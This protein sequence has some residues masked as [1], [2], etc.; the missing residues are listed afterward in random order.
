M[1]LFFLLSIVYCLL[2]VSAVTAQHADVLSISFPS[3]GMRVGENTILSVE[4]PSITLDTALIVWKLDN[5]EVARGIGAVSTD[6]KLTD[7]KEHEL[8]VTVAEKGGVTRTEKV[9][10][11]ASDLDLLWEAETLTPPMYAGRTL[12]SVESTVR[13]EVI[14]NDAKNYAPGTHTYT[15]KLNGRTLAA[16]S[17]I[18]K[19]SVRFQLPTFE[20]SALLQVSVRGIAGDFTG[21]TSVRIQTVE[22]KIVFYERKA[23]LGL[24]TN[25]TI[26]SSAP[27]TSGITVSAFPYFIS[28]LSQRDKNLEYSWRLG[29][30]ASA[31][32]VNEG[33]EDAY[34][35]DVVVPNTEGFS[36]T[37]VN[38][39]TLLQEARG[40]GALPMPG[41]DE[42]STGAFG[43]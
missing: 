11:K 10:L 29:A 25:S 37:V 26:S 28:A 30:G 36:V 13:A 9:T 31:P 35:S 16:Q 34:P 38:K 15:W 39:K 21:Q 17:G 19:H 12:P 22:P 8:A 40:R 5:L 6:I 42:G 4:S 14:I 43:I 24:W 1:R 3:S 20:N 41:S 7:T 18:G 2:S 33:G 27:L 32:Q 23:L